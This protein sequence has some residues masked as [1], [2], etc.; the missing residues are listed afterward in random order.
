MRLAWLVRVYVVRLVSVC[1][2]MVSMHACI[3]DE[4]LACVVSVYLIS[5]CVVSMWLARVYVV[6]VSMHMFDELG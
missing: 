6:S 1:V 4:W 5:V 3:L 2:V